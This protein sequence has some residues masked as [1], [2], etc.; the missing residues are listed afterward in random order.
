MGQRKPGLWFS[1]LS[2][3]VQ[4]ATPRMSK[5]CCDCDNVPQIRRLVVKRGAGRHATTDV[6]CLSCG[7]LF[8]RH[9]ATE[10]ERAQTYLYEGQV[11]VDGTG[12]IRL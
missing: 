1:T 2:V 12:G 11:G 8:L 7:D 3:E 10:C 5:V 4:D 6:Y 9:M